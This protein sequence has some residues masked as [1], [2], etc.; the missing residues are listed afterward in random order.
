MAQLS[1]EFFQNDHVVSVA[2]NLLGKVLVSTVNGTYSSGIITETEAYHQ[3]ERACH[4]YNGRRTKRTECL[5]HEGGKAYIYLCYG[6]HHLFNVTTGKKNEAA[7]VLVRA[8]EPLQ[9]VREMML[10]RKKEQLISNL[11][12]G[13]GVLTQALG[14]SVKYSG[15]VLSNALGIWIEQGPLP[16]KEQDIIAKPRIGVAYAGEDALL[17]WRFYLKKNKWV[18]KR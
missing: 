1:P 16:V 9:G 13:P 10:R 5:F 11:T 7:A 3:S 2:R 4:A 15:G 18:S 6:L 14:I 12:A 17:P 8:L